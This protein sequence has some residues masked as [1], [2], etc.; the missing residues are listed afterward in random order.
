MAGKRAWLE[1]FLRCGM[2][3]IMAKQ[4]IP[5]VEEREIK[6]K[7]LLHSQRTFDSLLMAWQMRPS[8]LSS[9]EEVLLKQAVEKARTIR[10]GVKFMVGE[11]PEA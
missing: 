8:D 6:E 7:L 1:I 5:S 10:D 2:L 9:E 3:F 4:V 11:A